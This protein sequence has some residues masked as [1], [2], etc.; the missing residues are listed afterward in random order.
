MSGPKPP[1]KRLP[2]LIWMARPWNSLTLDT[3]FCVTGAVIA[4][5]GIPP[6]VPTLLVTIAAALIHSSG[7]VL[8]DLTDIEVDKKL[9]PNRPLATGTVTPTDVL[10]FWA[11]LS[12]IAMAIGWYLDIRVFG[13]MFLLWL[14]GIFYSWKPRIKDILAFN[15]MFVGISHI[16]QIIAAAWAVGKG[17]TPTLL[18]YSLI[19]VMWIFAGRHWRSFIDYE[20]DMK[21]GKITLPVK[22]GVPKASKVVGFIWAFAPVISMLAILFKTMSPAFCFV[23]IFSGAFAFQNGID[24]ASDPSPENARNMFEGRERSILIPLMGWSIAF[25][26]GTLLYPLWVI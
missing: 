6:L 10:V 18:F 26:V 14:F 21:Y 5:G 17:I 16:F 2:A 23:M 1:G 22:L 13:L 7:T 20:T 11:A 3:M 12:G 9:F 15:E 8:N 4:V 24:L 25:I 19:L